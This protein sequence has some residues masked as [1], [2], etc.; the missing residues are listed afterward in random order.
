MAVQPAP[1][2]VEES[3]AAPAGELKQLTILFADLAGST[4]LCEG[5]DPEQVHELINA[6]VETGAACPAS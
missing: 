1:Q 5:M 3:Q 6:W 2:G 4:A